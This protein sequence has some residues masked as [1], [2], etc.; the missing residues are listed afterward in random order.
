MR[1][2]NPVLSRLEDGA[3]LVARPVDGGYEFDVRLQGDGQTV[4]FAV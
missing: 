4:F 2:S 3:T 1:A